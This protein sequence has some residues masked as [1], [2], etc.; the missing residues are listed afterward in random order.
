MPTYFPDFPKPPSPP[1]LVA[2][3]RNVAQVLTEGNEHLLDGQKA[4]EEFDNT[5]KK[6][7][8]MIKLM[9]PKR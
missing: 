9:L 7:G 5:R 1:N 8:R 6:V 2:P 4:L 3:L